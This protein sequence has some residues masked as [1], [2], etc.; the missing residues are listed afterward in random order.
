MCP[1][2]SEKGFTL[3]ELV[4][5]GGLTVTAA[6]MGSLLLSDYLATAR[7]LRVQA[8]AGF[9]LASF[10]KNITRDFQT[11]STFQR[12]CVLKRVTGNATDTNP[13]ATNFNCHTDQFQKTDGIGFNITGNTP[14]FAYINSCEKY[15]DK[16]LP[17]AK[18]G[19]HSPPDSPSQLAW[20]GASS[21]CPAACPNGYRPV[22]RYL[23]QND[24]FDSKQFPQTQK[25]QTSLELWGAV[26]C[27]S[28]FT[29][30]REI[31]Q[32]KG[33]DFS[34]QYM[35]VLAF[36]GR[37]RFDIKFPKI[38]TLPGG[39]VKYQSY[40]WMTGGVVLD[41]LDSQEMAIFKCPATKPDC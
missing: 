16:Q 8:A 36:V 35:N 39:G 31:Q 14:A 7:T 11:S 17:K 40:V 28:Q 27:A 25:G 9:E 24:I 34:A 4:I 5:A 26:V 15:D 12:A 32:L 19:K 23:K 18:G 1:M 38:G 3:V 22:V 37:G 41:F 29:D 33:R 20:G 30:L 13:T 10:L 21:I 6:L 2:R